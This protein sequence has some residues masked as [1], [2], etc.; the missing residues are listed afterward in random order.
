MNIINKELKTIQDALTEG[1]SFFGARYRGAGFMRQRNRVVRFMLASLA[2][3]SLSLPAANAALVTPPTLDKLEI[4][5]SFYNVEFHTG[6]FNQLYHHHWDADSARSVWGGGSPAFFGDV[7]EASR[8]LTAITDALDSLYH[9]P[10][11]A[12]SYIDRLFM[13]AIYGPDMAPGAIGGNVAGRIGIF[14]GYFDGYSQGTHVVGAAGAYQPDLT[15]AI[16]TEVPGVNT[17]SA[18]PVPAAVWL[19][20]TALAGLVGFG[21]RKARIAA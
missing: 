13:P 19:F 1:P 4:N 9:A 21:K 2:L 20:G 6:S 8:A 14:Q 15:W 7:A 17:P 11:Y 3:F 10:K 16:L 5:G 12:G 18:V